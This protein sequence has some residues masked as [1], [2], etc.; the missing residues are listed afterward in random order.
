M[1]D[2]KPMRIGWVFYFPYIFIAIIFHL[3]ISLCYCL[4]LDMAEANSV[5]FLLK[6]GTISLLFLLLPARRFRTRL[7]AT[8]SSALITLVF[9][10]W[11]L[12]AGNKELVLCLQAACFAAFLS[13]TS[14]KKYGWIISASLFL[15]C[16][17]GAIRQC[18]LE[19]TFNAA[20][21]YIVDDGQSCGA[22]GHCFQYIA[23]K[24]RGVAAK[25]QALFSSE[26]YVNIYY[27]YPEGIPAVNFDGMKNEF[28]QYLLCHGELKSVVREGKATCD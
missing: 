3:F 27:S 13:M 2:D 19:Q 28:A 4:S 6:P 23:A 9:N 10:Q 21:I 1:V 8:L 15:V 5:V 25:R 17:A 26:E 18:W 22:S 24:G 16:A 14:I 11:H 12:V 7:L 20:D